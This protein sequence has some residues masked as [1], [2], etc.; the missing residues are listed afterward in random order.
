LDGKALLQEIRRCPVD[1]V[2]GKNVVSP[3]PGEWTSPFEGKGYEPRGYRDFAI[4]DNPHRINLP[5]TARRGQPTIVERV[6]L[7]DFKLMVVVDA[8]PSMRVREKSTVQ[9]E[10]AALLLYSAWQAETTFTLAL[11]TNEGVRSFGLGI[12]SRHFYHLYRI[13]WGIF[14]EGEGLRTVGTRIH[15]SR[16]LPPN[17]ML[18]YCSDFLD[19]DGGIAGL[20]MLM[21]AVRRYDFIPIVI[22]DELEYDFPQTSYGSYIPFSNPETGMQEEVWVSPRT[23]EAIRNIHASRF[24][25][26]TTVFSSRG[27]KYLHLDAPGVKGIRQ[28]VSAFFGQRKRRKSA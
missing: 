9:T 21:R 25:E 15:L 17:A 23:A 27:I 11:R 4:G 3:Y 26:L 14:H 8:S 24:E 2:P 10:I 22:Q 28:S 19:A 1:F 13:L 5:A 7:R 12:G 6:A 20:K 16:C 18:L